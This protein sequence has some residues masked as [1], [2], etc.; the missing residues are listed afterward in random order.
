MYFKL[1][2]KN[3]IPAKVTD[4]TKFSDTVKAIFF[5]LQQDFATQKKNQLPKSVST[6]VVNV[7]TDVPKKTAQTI[8]SSFSP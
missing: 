3:I 1:L 2:D 8:L 4:K 7:K 5:K 6:K